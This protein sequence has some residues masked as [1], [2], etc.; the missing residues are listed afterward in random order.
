MS[1]LTFAQCQ[2][3]AR[4]CIGTVLNDYHSSL[5]TASS[6]AVPTHFSWE[7][8]VDFF[9]SRLFFLT[10]DG[11]DVAAQKTILNDLAS[12]STNYV[13][14]MDIFT[15]SIFQ[16]GHAWSYLPYNQYAVLIILNTAIDNLS[17]LESP[18]AGGSSGGGS[19][20]VEAMSE[21]IAQALAIVLDPIIVTIN[22]E[23]LEF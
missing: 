9:A 17:L 6:I 5:V 8:A 2:A 4:F 22:S 19:I 13:Y 11:A 18:V 20:D 12:H 15:R 10:K 14:L 1:K 23:N 16:L 3:I 21:T 7:R